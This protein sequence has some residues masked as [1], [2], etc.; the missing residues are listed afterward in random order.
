MV[1]QG[2]SHWLH[3]RI[4]AMQEIQADR[5]YYAITLLA[6]EDGR[7]EFSTQTHWEG[8]TDDTRTKEIRGPSLVNPISMADAWRSF[9]EPYVVVNSVTDLLIFLLIGG[10]A[11]AER[12]IAEAHFT[13]FMKPEPVAYSGA[14]GF[15]C[16]RSVP[17]LALR[18]APTPKLRMKIIKR[19]DHR[20]KICG[21]WP[22]DHTD[23]ELH[24][25][26]IRPWGRGGLTDERNLITVCHTCHEGL[27]PHG[28]EALFSFVEQ[29]GWSVDLDRERRAF[30]EGVRRYRKKIREL[31]GTIPR[32]GSPGY[33]DLS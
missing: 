25:H 28:D 15:Q 20:C 17:E 1:A 16:L 3:D 33:Q 5:H 8:F 6:P 12:G 26:H 29:S 10:N 9:G 27:A 23:V 18:R 31:A 7:I 4:A 32:R 13:D 22:S 2:G 24:V 19:D 30:F 11:L 14:L 21:R